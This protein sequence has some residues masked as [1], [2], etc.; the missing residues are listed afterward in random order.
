LWLLAVLV[1]ASLH[2]AE[3]Q[4]LKAV[5]RL[6]YVTGSDRNYPSPNIEL[7]RQGLR[8]IGYVEGKNILVEYRYAEGKMDRS[9]TLV[10]ELVQLNVDFLVT[11]CCQQSMPPPVQQAN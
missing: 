2:L 9:H 3:A 10:G 8:D 11:P 6:G 7:F 5:P 1:L 4:Q